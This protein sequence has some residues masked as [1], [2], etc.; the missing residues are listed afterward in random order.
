MPDWRAPPEVGF[1]SIP[2]DTCGA[3]NA[4]SYTLRESSAVL[5]IVFRSTLLVRSDDAVWTSGLAPVTSRVVATEVNS[6]VTLSGTVW[7][8]RTMIPRLTFSA[9][10]G[11]VT[12]TVYVPGGTRENR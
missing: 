2:S 10:L 6:S 5:S 1:R 11:A 4:R 12:V 7:L 9:K 8:A 3:R